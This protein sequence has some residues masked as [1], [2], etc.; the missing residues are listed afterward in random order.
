MGTSQAADGLQSSAQH[1]LP[2]THTRADGSVGT[3]LPRHSPGA[4]GT[5]FAVGIVREGPVER[6]TAVRP[7]RVLC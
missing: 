3:M 5:C 1:H 7:G 6:L 4:V 2:S